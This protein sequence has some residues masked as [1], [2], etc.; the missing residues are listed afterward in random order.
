MLDPNPSLF[1]ITPGRF[2]A[3][4]EI[5]ALIAHIVATYDVKFEE[6]KGFRAMFAS[7]NCVYPGKRMFCLGDGRSEIALDVDQ[8]II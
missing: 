5:K 3:V 7:L 6:G 1:G 4:N 2:F 8:A